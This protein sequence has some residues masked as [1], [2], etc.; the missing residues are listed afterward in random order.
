MTMTFVEF[1]PWNPGIQSQLPK[2]VLPLSTLLRPENVFQSFAE[3]MELSHF[4]GLLKE[5]VVAF[6]PERLVVHELL[7]RV[8]ANYAVSDGDEYEALGVNFRIMARTIHDGYVLKHMPSLVREYDQLRDEILAA[9]GLELDKT[10]FAPVP[11]ETV[12]PT[13]M[14]RLLGKQPKQKVKVIETPEERDVGFIQHWEQAAAGAE[15]DSVDR[16][17]YQSLARICGAIMAKYGRIRGEKDVLQRLV[18]NPVCNSHGSQLLG[19]LLEPILADG[20]ESE[21][22]PLL[23]I[24]MAPV[25][26]NVKGS[27]ASGKSTLRPLQQKLASSLGLKWEEFAL[28]SPDIWRKYLLEYESLGEHYKYAGAC[29]GQELKIVD[30]KLDAYMT[31]KGRDQGMPHLLIDRFRFDSFSITSSEEGSNLLTRFGSRVY[32]FYMITPPHATVERAWKR[33]VQVGR[34]KAV[35]DL[36]DHNVEA[37]TGMPQI[38]FTWALD[39]DKDVHYEFLDNSVEFGQRPRTVAFGENGVLHILDI[40]RIMDIDRFRKV[41]INATSAETV[42]PSGDAMHESNNTQFLKSCIERINKVDFVDFKTGEVV[43]RTEKGQLTEWCLPGLER[44][45]ASQE[46]RAALLNLFDSVKDKRVDEISEPSR[47]DL[48]HQQTLGQSGQGQEA[49]GEAEASPELEL[50]ESGSL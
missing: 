47:V 31:E 15:E 33:G 42:Y 50:R 49:S 44:A 36:L 48:A 12:K 17:I 14:Q 30:Q 9:V 24:Q 29:T 19:H 26:M 6:R 1:G 21:G 41:N 4:T 13:F 20:A 27:S 46:A 39:Q 8:S 43:A 37:F 34:F 10:L 2:E 38:F 25:I 40:E 11:I 23:P 7:I 18:S 22:F 45:I 32:M 28:I 5:D 35:D 16:L 3:I